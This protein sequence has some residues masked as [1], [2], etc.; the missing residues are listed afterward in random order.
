MSLKE[1]V[2]MLIKNSNA[3]EL[4]EFLKENSF[5]KVLRIAKEE[6]LLSELENVVD[7]LKSRGYIKYMREGEII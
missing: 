3:I 7:K 6:K 2:L 4:E 1:K 5:E